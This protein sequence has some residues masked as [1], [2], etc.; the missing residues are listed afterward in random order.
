MQF[1]RWTFQNL[2]VE[3]RDGVE[4][5][6]SSSPESFQATPLGVYEDVSNSTDLHFSYFA[7][8]VADGVEWTVPDPLPPNRNLSDPDVIASVVEATPI[9]LPTF[10]GNVTGDT[11]EVEL[12][13][14]VEPPA[15]PGALDQ[16]EVAVPLDKAEE[17]LDSFIDLATN[18]SAGRYLRVPVVLRFSLKG[19]GLLSA[20]NDG[21][22]LWFNL[23]DHVY[24]N[25]EYVIVDWVPTL[26]NISLLSRPRFSNL[27]F[28]QL[29]AHLVAD[30]S[31]SPSRLHFGKA[32]FPDFGCWNGAEH[33]KD[34]WCDFGCAVRAL[35]PKDKF[36][37]SA[38]DRCRSRKN[39]N[40]D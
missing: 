34:T 38:P 28:K 9:L 14:P 16:Y 4:A 31:C 1:A 27:P 30:E 10:L 18:L 29:I 36:V 13:R 19:S 7:S 25:R 21:A 8:D 6:N 20:S 12:V 39:P 22:I 40:A 32:G 26:C 33:Y 5:S 23:N 11:H 2:S 17:C 24:Y 15:E 3:V 37:G 35:D